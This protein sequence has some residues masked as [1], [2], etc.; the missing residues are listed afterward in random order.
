MRLQIRDKQQEGIFLRAFFQII[1]RESGLVIYPVAV[2]LHRLVIIIK[3]VTAVRMRR[4]FQ[5]IC[6]QPVLPATAQFFRHR[7][8]IQIRQVPFPDISS[9]VTRLIEQFRY[10]NFILAQR[11]IIAVTAVLR[12]IT[13]GLQAGS[14]RATNRLDGE[15]IFKFNPLTGKLI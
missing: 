5:R 9:V 13:P 12:W 15:G 2:E 7:F 11:D 4:M 14:R 8:F 10:R 6:R 3:K 1:E